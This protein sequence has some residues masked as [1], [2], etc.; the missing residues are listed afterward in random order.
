[1][2]PKGIQDH[3][4]NDGGSLQI[5]Q[6]RGHGFFSI[7]LPE[8]TEIAFKWD[9]QV[10]AHLAEEEWRRTNRGCEGWD[11]S[12]HQGHS[13]QKQK[14]A[15]IA[16]LDKVID[17]GYISPGFVA[18]QTSYFAVPKE[19]HDIC[20]VYDGTDSGLNDALWLVSIF[21]ASRLLFSSLTPVVL[22]R[23]GQSQPSNPTID[24]QSNGLKP[25]S[26]HPHPDARATLF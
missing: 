12:V 23:L 5:H 16:K 2:A 8:Q 17:R 9:H 18:N 10:I 11:A 6:A 15:M 4:L 22:F 21:L 20:L 3:S 24:R 14:G 13:P 19:E 7:E 1:L 25:G 26:Q